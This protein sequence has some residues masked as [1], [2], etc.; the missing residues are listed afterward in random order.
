[1]CINKASGSFTCLCQPHLVG[2][3]T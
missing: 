2:R 3:A 1:M